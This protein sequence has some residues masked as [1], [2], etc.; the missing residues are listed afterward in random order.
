MVSLAVDTVERM[1]PEM[2]WGIREAAIMT[3]L[4]CGTSFGGDLQPVYEYVIRLPIDV[5]S[6]T[7]LPE[8]LPQGE[9]ILLGV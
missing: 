6:I 3:A 2:L 9:E 5:S 8:E 1:I 7:A 4:P